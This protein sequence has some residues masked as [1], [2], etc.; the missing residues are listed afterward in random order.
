MIAEC[1]HIVAGGSLIFFFL[2]FSFLISMYIIVLFVFYFSIS[3]LIILISYFVPFSFIE[4]LILF[5][6]V[7]QL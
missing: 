7:L 3:V 2:L 4:V 5:N 6:L 1:G